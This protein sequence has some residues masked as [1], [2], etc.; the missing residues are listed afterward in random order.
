MKTEHCLR[1]QRKIIRSAEQV[2]DALE[3]CIRWFGTGG[4][5]QR[6]AVDARIAAIANWE[7]TIA[8]VN[9]AKPLPDCAAPIVNR[10]ALK[11]LFKTEVHDRASTVDDNDSQDWYSLTLGWAIAKG[12]TPA[13]AHKFATHI[14]YST[15]LG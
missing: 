7:K 4:V 6:R 9:E 8:A 3:R 1:E 10:V 12:L 11:A 13:D 2:F 14:R 5:Q 15:D